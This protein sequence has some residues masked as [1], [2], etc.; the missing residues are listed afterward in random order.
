MEHNKKRENEEIEIDISQVLHVILSKGILIILIG[1]IVAIITLIYNT[2]VIKPMYTSTTDL[3]II[4]R[5]NNGTTTLSDVQ[6][7]SQLMKDFQILVKSRSVTEQAISELGLDMTAN[8]LADN[9]E[10]TAPSDTRVLE[11]SVTNGDP[12]T[13]KELAD[14]IAEVAADY[15][16]NIMQ[17]EQISVIDKAE[18]AEKP[19]SPNI[20]KNVIIGL[21]VGIIIAGLLFVIKFILDDTVNTEEDIDKYFGL[22]TLALIPLSDKLDDSKYNSKEKY[23]YN[24]YSKKRNEVN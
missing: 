8:Q 20:I 4:T 1:A 14:K 17:I 9:I 19:S 2:M 21:V 5:Q 12:Y 18:V 11:I 3:Y 7:S 22:S 15:S 24:K 16:G 13:A 23:K 10:I 6:T